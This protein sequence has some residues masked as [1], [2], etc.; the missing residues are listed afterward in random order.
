MNGSDSETLIEFKDSLI[1]GDNLTTWIHN[2]TP[3]NN[4]RPNWEGI[5][6][7]NG[8]IW[9]IKLE[10]KG[11][12]GSI[13]PTILA[14]LP[15]LVSISFKNNSLEGSLPDFRKLH[16]MQEI[17]LSNNKFYGEI[18]AN[19]FNGLNRLTKLYLANNELMGHIPVSLTTLPKLKELV[20][21]NNHFDGQIPNFDPGK[22][23][24]A[25]FANNHLHG[26]IPEGLRDSPGKRVLMS[27]I[28]PRLAGYTPVC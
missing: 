17:F 27:Y 19:A 8:N 2:N 20:L 14:R 23:T 24:L 3:C 15:S 25:N 26:R 28:E 22:L 18:S 1:N 11:L 7:T 5:L 12:E 16:G 4:N 10:G 21:D 6:C 13:D 9:G